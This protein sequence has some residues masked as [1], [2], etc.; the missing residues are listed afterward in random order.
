LFG[1]NIFVGGLLVKRMGAGSGFALLAAAWFALAENAIDAHAAAMSEA[2]CLSCTLLAL[3]AT[4]IYLDN[5]RLRWLV[6]SGVLAALACLARYAAL[7]LVAA[8]A[9]ALFA[10]PRGQKLPRRL[11]DAGLFG[12]ISLIPPALY[13]L[14]SALLLGRPFYY[15]AYTSEPFT[16]ENLTWYLY[17]TLSWFVPGRLIRDRELLAG[18]AVVFLVAVGVIVLWVNRRRFPGDRP[19]LSVGLWL[20]LLYALMN[21]LMLFFARG[22]AGLAAYN[23]RYLVLP[24]LALLLALAYLLD[25]IWQSGGRLAR[26]SVAVIGVIFLAY[27]GYRAVDFTRSMYETGQGYLN[28]GWHQSETVP[29]LKAHAES[30]LVATGDVGIYFW[31]GRLPK[32]ITGFESLDAMR[33]YLC[34][35]HGLLVIMKQMPTTIY[36]MDEADVV[37]ELELEQEF[38]DGVVYR[39]VK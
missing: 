13:L 14:R 8:I 27:Y 19:D 22:L 2:L 18:A 16:L 3:L 15:P 7:P 1:V 5:R 9:L 10:L 34:E 28:I 33:A 35:N 21:Y 20:L 11:G 39:C 37:Q 32:P 36:H 17:N 31:T 24:L 29:Y 23:A 12:L 4:V 26:G 30:S 6:A 25:R 38:N